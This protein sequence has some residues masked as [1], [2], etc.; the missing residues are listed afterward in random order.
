MTGDVAGEGDSAT[1]WSWGK[2]AEGELGG[3][4]A[5]AE[6]V[7][8][9]LLMVA[10]TGDAD[11]WIDTLLGAVRKCAK[12]IRMHPKVNWKSLIWK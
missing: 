11:A 6:A 9:I 4:D 1:G 7:S 12:L 10:S 8:H 2:S 3:C 5:A